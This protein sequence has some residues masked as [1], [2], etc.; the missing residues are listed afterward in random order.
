M[1]P[2]DESQ[3]LKLMQYFKNQKVTFHLLDKGVSSKCFKALFFSDF[4]EKTDLNPTKVILFGRSLGGA[5]AI[6]SAF[7]AGFSGHS[8]DLA[9][10]VVE[11]T[12]T[13]IADMA[14]ALFHIPGFN[15]LPRLVEHGLETV[16]WIF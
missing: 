5:V 13:R 8:Q 11:N 16:L 7:M 3:M 6:H 9:M 4:S 2:I 1:L 14:G 15:C 10:L 12:F